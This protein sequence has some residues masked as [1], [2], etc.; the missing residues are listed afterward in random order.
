M[1]PELAM[2]A[3]DI[4]RPDPPY[5]F[6]IDEGDVLRTEHTVQLEKVKGPTQDVALRRV[7]ARRVEFHFAGK[8]RLGIGLADAKFTSP[9][10][11]LSHLT[12]RT[13][14]FPQMETFLSLT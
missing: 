5:L 7:Q 8:K 9:I 14:N 2:K 1:I 6:E 10:V 4:F 3:R 13:T 12:H 11:R